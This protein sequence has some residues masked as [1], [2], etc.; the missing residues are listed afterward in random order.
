MDNGAVV[1]VVIA[2]VVLALVIAV[3]M[4]RRSHGASRVEGQRD[5]ARE[6]RARAEADQVDLQRREAE[7]AKVDAQARMAQAEADARAADAA[8]LQVQARERAEHADTSRAELD[9]Q[10]RRADEIDPDVRTDEAGRKVVDLRHEPTDV[11]AD[12]GREQRP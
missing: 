12:E 3:V 8:A 10:L 6:L 11:R 5:E 7:A 4:V 2:L 1:W 9:Q